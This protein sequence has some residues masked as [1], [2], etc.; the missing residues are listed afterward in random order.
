M[1]LD[2]QQSFVVKVLISSLTKQSPSRFC[3]YHHLKNFLAKVF[4]L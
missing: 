3:V 1:S 2:I 4:I